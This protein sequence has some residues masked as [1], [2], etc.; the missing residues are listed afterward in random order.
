MEREKERRRDL[1]TIAWRRLLKRWHRPKGLFKALAAKVQHTWWFKSV[2]LPKSQHS[3]W[4]QLAKYTRFH[5][6]V[7]CILVFSVVLC[8]Q[9]KAGDSDAWRESSS[10]PGV[11]GMET[12]C[13]ENR[14]HLHWTNS[15]SSQFL[16]CSARKGEDELQCDISV[17]DTHCC[18][19]QN[20]LN[21]AYCC[22]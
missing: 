14:H 11:P 9:V 2:L 6:N 5:F 15:C 12:F 22:F 13:L 10:S 18:C 3:D 17:S 1:T 19:L 16:T 4:A 20:S 8:F 21:L 7:P